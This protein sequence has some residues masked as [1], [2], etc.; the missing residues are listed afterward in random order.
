[1]YEH[2]V[3]TVGIFG[4]SYSEKF[5]EKKKKNNGNIFLNYEL[6]GEQTRK[7]LHFSFRSQSRHISVLFCLFVR[8]IDICLCCVWSKCGNKKN[9]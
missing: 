1:M 6:Q 9:I 2:N 5:E 3:Y 4:N 8:I 7:E